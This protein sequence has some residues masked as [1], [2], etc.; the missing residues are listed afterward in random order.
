MKRWEKSS[1]LCK[2][3]QLW[4][5]CCLWSWRGKRK[6]AIR[7][8]C[9]PRGS[10]GKNPTAVQKT[11]VRSLDQEDPLE[12]DMATHASTLAWRIPWTEEPGRLWSMGS[13]RV[14][15]D[16][17]D[18]AHSMPKQEEDGGQPGV[19]VDYTS[20][21]LAYA[22]YT[23]LNLGVVSFLGFYS[24]QSSDTASLI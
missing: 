10:D 4:L 23:E 12:K 22:C 6:P 3:M 5:R 2:Y 1:M 15:H 21:G 11:W 18:W 20:R 9:F 7:G 19:W 8:R 14:R 13:Q 16:W 17:S 24:P